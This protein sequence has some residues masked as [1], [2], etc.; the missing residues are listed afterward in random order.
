MILPAAGATGTT[1][2]P[3]TSR[4]VWLVGGTRPKPSSWPRRPALRPPAASPL[5][6]ASGQH[7]AMVTQALARSTGP[8]PDLR[9]SASPAPRPSWSPGCTSSTPCWRSATRRGP[10]A[11][12]H[13][14]HAGRGARRV[15]AR[16]PVAHLEAG[17]RT[18]DLY[19]RSPRRGTGSGRPDRRAAP[20]AD[21]RRGERAR[22][23]A[24]PDGHDRGHRQHRR[25][26][27]AAGRRRDLPARRPDLAAA[28]RR[29]GRRRAPADAR[30]R[31]PARVVGRAAD[32]RC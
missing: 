23:R 8:G 25:G 6:V 28:G 7:P 31:A 20:G 4:T 22:P 12:R 11:G 18:G 24:V 27:R 10:R 21:R 19:P 3:T 2:S 15:L 9:S 1:G 5:L 14:H 16:I 30:H 26:R 32:A 29:A 13:H 17:L